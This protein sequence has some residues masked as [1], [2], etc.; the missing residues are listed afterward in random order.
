MRLTPVQR[1]ILRRQ[2]AQMRDERSRAHPWK[3]LLPAAFLIGP[4]CALVWA[5]IRFW[6]HGGG[7]EWMAVGLAIGALAAYAGQLRLGRQMWPLYRRLMRADELAAMLAEDE[8]ARLAGE[9]LPLRL[10]L[11]AGRIAL[12]GIGGA[13]ALVLAFI[14]WWEGM[15]TWHDPT[16]NTAG[17]AVKVYTATWCGPCKTV[18]AHLRENGVAFDELDVEKSAAA[19]WGWQA[20]RSRGV[21]VTVIDN[22]V[23][24]GANLP[25]IDAALLAAGHPLPA[26]ARGAAGIHMDGAQSA[27]TR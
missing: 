2:L 27:L 14:A 13:V 19:D 12:A 26:P 18:K 20:T 4:L 11:H 25:R 21:P 9:P 16:R 15:K 3:Q 5:L 7:L 23:Y 24:R 10:P 22:R 6:L 8:R 1:Q 17:R